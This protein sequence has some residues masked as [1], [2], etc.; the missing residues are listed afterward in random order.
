MSLAGAAW[1]IADTQGAGIPPW[2]AKEVASTPKARHQGTAGV[3]TGPLPQNKK[4][5]IKR[6]V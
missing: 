5:G 3:A 1:K 6:V 4:G 2:Y